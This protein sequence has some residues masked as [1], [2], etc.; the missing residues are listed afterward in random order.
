MLNLTG[1]EI[2]AF[3]LYICQSFAAQRENII[4]ANLPVIQIW[5]YLPGTMSDKYIYMDCPVGFI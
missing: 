5:N 2:L 4:T 1:E 3:R